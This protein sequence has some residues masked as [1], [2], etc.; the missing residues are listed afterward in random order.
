MEAMLA[1][2]T[3]SKGLEPNLAQEVHRRLETIFSAP[4]F[5]LHS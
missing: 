2:K 3:D 5:S 1:S 4:A